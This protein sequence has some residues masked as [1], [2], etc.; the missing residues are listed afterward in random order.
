MGPADE[1]KGVSFEEVVD[2]ASPI[3]EA[4]SSLEVVLPAESLWIWV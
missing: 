2:D 4:D 3:Q 1:V